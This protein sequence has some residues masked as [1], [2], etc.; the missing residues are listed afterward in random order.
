LPLQLRRLVCFFFDRKMVNMRCG[1]FILTRCERCRQLQS[2]DRIN[3][4]ARRKVRCGDIEKRMAANPPDGYTF[5][6]CN[7][8]KRKAKFVNSAGVSRF[9]TF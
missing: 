9:V 8:K 6:D 4:T 2:L 7:W 5:I 3:Y 1:R